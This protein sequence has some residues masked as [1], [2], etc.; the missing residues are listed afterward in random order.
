MCGALLAARVLLLPAGIGALRRGYISRA[1]RT[2]RCSIVG[3]LTVPE[4][5]LQFSTSTAFASDIIRRLTHSE[6]SHVDAVL[7][8]GL[9]GVSGP[10]H[11]LGDPGGVRIR[12]FNPWPYK[13]P[14]KRVTLPTPKAAAIIA[15]A[16]TQIGKP[17]DQDAIYAFLS[18]SPGDRSWREETSWYCSEY[19]AWNL[20]AEGFFPYALVTAKNRITPAD[21]LLLINPFM[22]GLDIRSFG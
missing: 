12:S 9:L 22:S 11:S 19:W 6:F 18:T 10:D 17:F 8:E 14:P 15:R 5:V 1:A 20:E 4:I 2:H 13:F 21:L 7:P 16:R 3:Y